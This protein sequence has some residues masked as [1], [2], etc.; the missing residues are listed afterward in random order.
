MAAAPTRRWCVH[1]S[2]PRLVQTERDDHRP[3]GDADVLAI[4]HSVRHWTRFPTLSCVEMP[5]QLSALGIRGDK[6]AAAVSIE[7]Q[8]AGRR[9]QAALQDSATNVRDLPNGLASLDIERLQGF[10]PSIVAG[11]TARAAAI[12][13]FP[14]F[15]PLI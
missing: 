5:K 9:Q 11:R 7:H 8:P 10:S 15:P 6:G 12:E 1:K 13:R 2:P 3:R 4:I 14:R